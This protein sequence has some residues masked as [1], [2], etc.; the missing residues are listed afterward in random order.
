MWQST[1]I[2]VSPSAPSAQTRAGAAP[3]SLCFWRCAITPVLHS[4]PA[5]TDRQRCVLQAPNVQAIMPAPA[6]QAPAHQAIHAAHQRESG[7]LHSDRPARS[8]LRPILRILRPARG[9]CALLV[10][11]LQLARTARRIETST[12]D[13]PTADYEQPGGLTHRGRK[14]CAPSTRTT[15]KHRLHRK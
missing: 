13:Q 5:R 6:T 12:A 11:S 8:G 15:K 4:F 10:A 1:I 2:R 3:A 9:P 7:S 14:L